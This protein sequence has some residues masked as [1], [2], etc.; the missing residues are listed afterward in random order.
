MAAGSGG[1]LVSMQEWALEAEAAANIA[2][3]LA[4]TDFVPDSLRRYQNPDERDPRKRVLDY[5][6]TVQTV[7]AVLLAGQELGFRPMASLRAF[8]I[9]RGTVAMYAV[10][11]RALLLHNG[12]EVI[13]VESTSQRAVVRA[14]RAD[15]DQWQMSMWDIPRAREAKLYPGHP[16]GNWSR[17][18][19]SMLVARATAEASR[20][21]AADA[22][23]GLPMFV[24]EV[25]DGG[26][27]DPLS[28]E[29]AP[30]PEGPPAKA[31]PA[32]PVTKQRKRQPPRAALPSAPPSADQ[33]PPPVAPVAAETVANVPM[34]TRPMMAK[35]H[36]GLKDLQI[37]DRDSGLALLTAWVGRKIES[38]SDLNREEMNVVLTRITSLLTIAA[39]P[40]EGGDDDQPDPPPPDEDLEANPP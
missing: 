28:I 32:A 11:A 13:V 4:P 7:A 34:P 20:W 1:E 29:A 19:K 15:S 23:L 37:T 3:A 6:A 22:M 26:M 10:A 12:H 38:T 36:A 30:A 8:T 17:Q 25:E 40:K 16:D 24:E 9:I 5:D 31:A 18:P 35:L 21:V 14:R 39:R 2:K 27:Y 33:P